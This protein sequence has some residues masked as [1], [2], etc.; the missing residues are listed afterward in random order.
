MNAP[1]L[2]VLNIQVEQIERQV[3]EIR[4]HLETHH[5]LAAGWDRA[6]LEHA[7]A[8]CFGIETLASHVHA[9]VVCAGKA[10]RP[11]PVC[12]N[13][14]KRDPK[15]DSGDDPRWQGP[16]YD[17]YQHQEDVEA[18][19]QQDEADAQRERQL[20]ERQEVREENR[21]LGQ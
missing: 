10:Q 21:R 15:P 4:R 5:L 14:G 12:T 17:K 20:E 13:D 1:T 7:I 2:E 3:Q 9:C 11:L 19:R 6:H 16:E 8:N 18:I